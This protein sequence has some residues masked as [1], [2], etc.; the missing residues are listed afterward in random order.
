MGTRLD[1]DVTTTVK[2]F[3]DMF[4]GIW[5]LVL[6]YIWTAKFDKTR[7]DRTMTWGRRHGPLPP[8]SCWVTWVPSWSCSSSA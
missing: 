4:I 3:I 5:A 1:R 7:G 8:A 2:I 6:A